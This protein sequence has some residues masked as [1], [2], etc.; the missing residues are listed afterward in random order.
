MLQ[1][2]DRNFYRRLAVTAAVVVAYRLGTHLP[3]PGLDV[4]K[5]ALMLGSTGLPV[6][7]ISPLALGVMPLL[8]ALI[9]AEIVKLLAPSV[10]SWENASLRNR[11]LMRYAVVGL[12]LLMGLLQA[13]GLASALEQV[14]GLVSEPGTAFR[15]VTIAT[16][17]AGLALAIG[18][19]GI[20][21]RLGLGSGLWLLFLTPVLIEF[22]LN[23]A[24]IAHVYE[25]GGYSLLAV[26]G[27]AAFTAIAI[28]GVVSILLAARGYAATA[29]TSVWTLPVA[30]TVLSWLLLG[31]GVLIAFSVEG[32][33]TFMAPGSLVRYLLLVATVLLVTWLYVRSFARAGKPSPVPAAAIGSTLAAIA[34]ASEMLQAQWSVALPLGSVQLVAATVVATTMLI[35]W[36]VIGGGERPADDLSAAQS[37]GPNR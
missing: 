20:I 28:A 27:S 11:E 34:L 18:F 3:L 24:A 13:A 8:A 5:V 25:S 29:A 23:L 4:E 17:L 26:L 19:I 36:K 16:M 30:Y 31:V 33:A 10:R 6:A 14:A 15:I 32:A 2:L 12:A 35:D 37:S 1:S 21:D 22:P 9:L 7:S